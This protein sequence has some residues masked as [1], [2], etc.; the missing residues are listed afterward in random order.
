M[1]PIVLHIRA[2]VGLPLYGEKYGFQNKK[3]ITYLR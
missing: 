1:I 2:T 3:N